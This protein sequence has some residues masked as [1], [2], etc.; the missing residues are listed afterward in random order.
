M[1][2]RRTA[3]PW[4]WLGAGVLVADQL[5]KIAAVDHLVAQQALP[6]A[7]SLNLTLT[8]NRGAAFSFL[9]DAG[10]WQRWLFVAIAV[11]VTVLLAVWLARL[12]RRARWTGASIGLVIGGAVGNLV[13]RL[14]RGA[15]VDFVDVYYGTWHWP[16]FNVADSAICV[17]AAILVLVSFASEHEEGGS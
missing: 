14:L 12:P 11:V 15:V 4:L 5:T 1:S 16:A 3:L 10:G 9:G 13:D 8:F 2:E 7:P 17:G 6:V